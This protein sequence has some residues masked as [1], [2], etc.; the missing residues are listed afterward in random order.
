[1]SC[2]LTLRKLCQNKC[3]MVRTAALLPAVQSWNRSS[4]LISYS[5][6][7]KEAWAGCM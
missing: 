6:S 5:C 1:M 4:H 2:G 7:N 3:S